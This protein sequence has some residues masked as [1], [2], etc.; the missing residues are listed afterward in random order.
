MADEEVRTILVQLR[1][2]VQ[3]GDQKAAQDAINQLEGK[4]KTL[5]TTVQDAESKFRSLRMAARELSQIGLAATM[6][7]TAIVGPLTLAANKYIQMAGAGEVTSEKWLEAQKQVESAEVRI[8]RVAAEQMLP[9]LEKGAEIMG[10]IADFA[11]QHPDAVRAALGIG[12]TLVALGG[13]TVTV[14]ELLKIYADVGLVLGKIGLGGTAATAATAAG[15]EGAVGAVGEGAIA[16]GVLPFVHMIAAAVLEY[17]IINSLAQIPGNYGPGSSMGVGPGTKIDTTPNPAYGPG[18]SVGANPNTQ[19]GGT[20]QK[21]S[22]DIDLLT[23]QQKGFMQAFVDDFK[24]EQQA[25]KTYLDT[26]TKDTSGFQ[27]QQVQELQDFQGNEAQIESANALKRMNELRDFDKQTVQ[28]DQDNQ[29][30]RIQELRDFA[31]QE[32]QAEQDYYKQR[33][34]AASTYDTEVQRME[35]DHQI[36]M[37]RS[38]QDHNQTMLGFAQSNDVLG[39]YQEISRYNTQRQR[40]E[41]DYKIQ[42]QRKSEDYAKQI[43]DMEANFV[44]QE[45]RRQDAFKQQI[46]DEDAQNKKEA[47]RRKTAFAQ[48]ISDENLQNKLEA[49]QRLEQFNKQRA[50]ESSDFKQKM[51]DL[52]QQFKDEQAIRKAAYKQQLIDLNGAEAQE[53]ALRDA[54]NQAMIASTPGNTS[55]KTLNINGTQFNS[56]MSASDM[57]NYFNQWLQQAFK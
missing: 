7:G 23:D 50:K 51:T 18:S 3:Q 33:T 55:S 29:A 6:I 28:I 14:A 43:A 52:A 42:A 39:A 19:P 15:A 21:S 10:R 54:Y 30:K 34:D 56:N 44:I 31:E 27:Q 46:S 4:T 1:F 9:A 26:V 24:A 45:Q 37:K 2:A 22:T 48:Q 12:G 5:G 25:Q 35:Q 11:E 8:G 17:F 57:Y 36:A 47:D 20:S 13:I 53:K 41:Q 32:A 49:D 16:T 38:Q 40:D